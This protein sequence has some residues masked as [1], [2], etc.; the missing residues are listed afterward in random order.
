MILRP[1]ESLVKETVNVYLIDRF[2]MGFFRANVTKL[3]FNKP[4]MLKIPTTRGRR[5]SSVAEQLNQRLPAD[6]STRLP[7][8]QRLPARTNPPG[9]MVRAELELGISSPAS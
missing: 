9:G 1:R 3:H 2:P 6:Y 7:A 4:K 8:D 5:C